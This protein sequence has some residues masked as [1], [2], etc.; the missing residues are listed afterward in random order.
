VLPFSIL[1][2]EGLVGRWKEEEDVFNSTLEERMWMR[3]VE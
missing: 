3:M 1:E 2:V